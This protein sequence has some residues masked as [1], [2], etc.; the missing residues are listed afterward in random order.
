MDRV[1]YIEDS[2]YNIFVNYAKE[3]KWY[4]R[5]SNCLLSDGDDQR[6][7][8][9]KDN[10][11]EPVTEH[12]V[13]NLVK[14]YP[15]WPYIDSFR[16]LDLEEKVLTTY[17]RRNTYTCS[18]TDGNYEDS[19]DWDEEYQCEN[20]GCQ[21]SDE[22]ELVYSEY[23]DTPGC[24]SCMSWSEIMQDWIPDSKV[25]YVKTDYACHNGE[26]CCSEYLA[27]CPEEY[28]YIEGSWYSTE[29]KGICKNQDGDWVV[30]HLDKASTS[31]D[32]FS[33]TS[34]ISAASG[35]ILFDPRTY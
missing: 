10:Y 13:L 8:S 3:N 19:E 27:S 28:V 35:T 6:F 20:C 16:Y 21:Y 29:F 30:T 24:T 17:R 33:V 32:M 23:F 2:L 9:P 25:V 34:S 31:S 26:V 5:E 4:I 12:F 14:I 11:T 1:Y 7:L 18:F 15:E 22:D